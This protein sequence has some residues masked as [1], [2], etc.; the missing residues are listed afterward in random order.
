[1]KSLGLVLESDGKPMNQSTDEKIDVSYSRARGKIRDGDWLLW[2]PTSLAGHGICWFTGQKYSHASMAGWSADRRLRN[3]EMIQWHGGRN[4]PLSPQISQWPGS[5]DV[6][7]PNDP[8]H[9]REALR[10]ML[11]LCSQKYGWG[12]LAFIGATK[13]FPRLILDTPANS[14]SP[15]LPRVCSVSVAFASRAGGKIQACPGKPDFLV[16]PGDLANPEIAKYMF[17]LWPDDT[18]ERV[19]QPELA[20]AGDLTGAY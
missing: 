16:K 15:D 4:L 9:R 10:Q 8:Y 18:R 1:M 12:N 14:D 19:H 13:L 5:C 17:T 11:W 7:R 6:W 2:K 3:V 20:V